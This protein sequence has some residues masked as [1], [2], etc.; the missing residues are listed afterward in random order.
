MTN[1]YTLALGLVTS[2]ALSHAASAQQ[3]GFYQGTSADGSN[4]QFTIGTD[5]ATGNL[6]VTAVGISLADACNPGAFAYNTAWGLG[7]DGTDLTGNKGTFTSSFG[8]LYVNATLTFVGTTV[9]GTVE[10]ATPTLVA[11]SSGTGEPTKAAYCKSKRQT[12]TA[13]LQTTADAQAAARPR[14]VLYGATTIRH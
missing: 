12:Y 9:K 2:L 11:T 3:A 14:A 4:I 5:S 1:R 6:Q 8:Y 7:G 13:T 10:N